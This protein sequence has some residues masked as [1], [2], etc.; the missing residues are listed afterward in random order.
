[1]AREGMVEL[2]IDLMTQISTRTT[3]TGTGPL[4]MSDGMREKLM[5]CK[6]AEAWTGETTIDDWG[7]GDVAGLKLQYLLMR[8][9]PGQ[10]QHL[11]TRAVVMKTGQLLAGTRAVAVWM[12]TRPFTE[13]TE[14]IAKR[15]ASRNYEN[16]LF[17]RRLCISLSS[18]MAVYR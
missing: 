14:G 7:G 13:V 17:G 5:Q 15:P 11:G 8:S 18:A 6:I 4:R 12:I 1:M 10:G 9:A 2:D 16:E 3:V